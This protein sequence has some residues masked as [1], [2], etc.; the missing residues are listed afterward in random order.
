MRRIRVWM[1]QV[2]ISVNMYRMCDMPAL[3]YGAGVWSRTPPGENLIN[4]WIN[5][6]GQVEADNLILTG[7]MTE[8]S[9]IYDG[10]AQRDYTPLSQR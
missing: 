4:T 6:E 3:E 9:L 7:T 1:F 2:E 8:D 5:P 10:P